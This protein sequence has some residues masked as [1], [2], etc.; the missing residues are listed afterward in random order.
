M[1]KI[2]ALLLFIGLIAGCSSTASRVA[3]GVDLNAYRHIWVEHQL[4]DGDSVDEN[5]ARHLR[6]WAMMPPPGPRP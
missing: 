4:S 1:K 5:I 3:A 6:A 2:V